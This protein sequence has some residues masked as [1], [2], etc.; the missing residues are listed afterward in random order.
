M[1]DELITMCTVKGVFQ[2]RK[3]DF[4]WL[5]IL[6]GVLLFLFL[7]ETHNFFVAM[8]CIHPYI[9]GFVKFFILATMGEFLALRIVSDQW[10][11]PAGLIFRAVIWGIIGIAMTL[12]MPVYAAG[13]SSAL[14]KGL[15]PG[16]TSKI[17]F[18]FFTSTFMNLIF[19]PTMMAAHRLTD[20]Y[21]DLIYKDKE[22]RTSLEQ[23]ISS[24]DWNNFISFVI[25]KTIPFFW[26]PAHTI[27]FLLPAEYR[28]LAAALLSIALG[29]ILS[30]AK[31]KTKDEVRLTV[32][33]VS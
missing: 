26:I 12:V 28:V 7:P 1:D 9:M 11:R 16:N 29:G 3:G 30:F 32:E 31:R 4:L 10:I 22:S 20:T 24:V 15:L 6:A 27:T 13:I 21:I 25:L 23:V 19:G 5:A 14:S 33:E 8:T 17:A 18:A 2:L